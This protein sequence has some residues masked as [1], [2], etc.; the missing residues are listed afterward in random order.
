MHSFYD[1]KR[2]VCTLLLPKSDLTGVI[3]YNL[4]IKE[5]HKVQKTKSHGAYAYWFRDGLL[6]TEKSLKETAITAQACFLRLS[7]SS[8]FCST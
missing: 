8:A 4:I 3:L 6:L 7:F 1:V 2:P 5:N